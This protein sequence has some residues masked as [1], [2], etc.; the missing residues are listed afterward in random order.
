MQGQMNDASEVLAAIFDCLHQ[1]H[2]SE[3]GAHNIES[4]ESKCIGSC[5]GRSNACIAHTLFGMDIQL[6]IK[7]YYCGLE[8]RHQKY[9]SFFRYINASNLRAVKVCISS[10]SCLCRIIPL[11]IAKSLNGRRD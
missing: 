4:E 1:A 10:K 11:T 5:D 8:S 9:T 3:F 6:E 2:A 7:C